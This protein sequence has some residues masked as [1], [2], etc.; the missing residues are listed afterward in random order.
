MRAARSS[1]S[2]PSSEVDIR[3]P[4]LEAASGLLYI[5]QRLAD[6]CCPMRRAL[7]LAGAF[8]AGLLFAI[9]SQA[10]GA[11]HE[12]ERELAFGLDIEGFTGGVIVS[13]NDGDVNAT[14]ILNRGP[15]I[16][17][18]TTPARDFVPAPRLTFT[19]H[20]FE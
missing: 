3:E 16:A 8:F 5:E 18:Y 6:Y 10:V 4:V 11:G 15:Q 14:L 9:P 2:I 20:G 17:Y 13:N 12:V 19:P 7:V 1:G